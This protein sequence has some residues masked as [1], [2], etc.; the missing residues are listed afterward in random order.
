MFGFNG[1]NLLLTGTGNSLQQGKCVNGL[2]QSLFTQVAF[3]NS[4]AFYRAAHRDMAQGLLKIPAL[5]TGSDGQACPT[6]RGFDVVD[7][8]QSDNVVSTYLLTASGQTAQDSA[9]NVACPG[10]RVRDQ[11]RQRQRPGQQVHGPGAGLHA[12]PVLGQVRPPVPAPA[13]RSPTS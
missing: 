4:P 13:R 7:Q 1:A 5:G 10:R 12:V 6:V 9:A 2:G 8:D 11:Q 3:C